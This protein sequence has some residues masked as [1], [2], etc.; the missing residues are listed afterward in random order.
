[1]STGSSTV[2]QQI[3]TRS[4]PTI[5]KRAKTDVLGQSGRTPWLFMA[6]YLVLF[7]L[8]VLIPAV[9]GLWMSLHNWD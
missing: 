5:S 6:P 9:Y 8:F 2:P 7:S 3:G 4:L 1:M